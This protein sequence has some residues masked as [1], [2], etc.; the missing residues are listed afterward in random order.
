MYIGFEPGKID[1]PGY[2][3]TR[4]RK[5]CLSCDRSY[6]GHHR[7]KYCWICT[8]AKTVVDSERIRAIK[9]GL[10]EHFTIVEWV[11]LCLKYDCKCLCC[12]KAATLSPDHIVPLSKGGMNTI[13]NIQPLCGRCNMSK[14]GRRSTDYRRIL[15]EVIDLTP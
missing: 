4:V 11:E 12:G 13:D 7:T 3:F 10:T 5:N 1:H 2:S 9:L 14:N 8:C 15:F 6:T